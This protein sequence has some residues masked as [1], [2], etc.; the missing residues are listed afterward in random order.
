MNLSFNLDFRFRRAL[1]PQGLRIVQTTN[2]AIL[3]A[4]QDC[5]N[6]GLDPGE[7]PAVKLLSRHLRRIV[8][9][10]DI[11]MVH[12]EDA[13]LRHQ[14]NVAIE[15]MR[16]QPLLQTLMRVRAWTDPDGKRSFHT[17]AARSLRELA[18]ALGLGRGDYDLRSNKAGPAVSGEI[19]LHADRLYVQI[20][21]PFVAGSEILYRRVDSR[22]DYTGKRNHYAAI[23]K[24]LDPSTLAATIR[25]NLCLENAHA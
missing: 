17:E 13:R 25:R 19:T 9:G 11:D 7:C 5:R 4:I 14:C 8:D 21:Q 24:A 12:P 2:Q 23:D 15:Q 20:S 10:I 3:E 16:A 22:T 18:K 1:Q 6:S